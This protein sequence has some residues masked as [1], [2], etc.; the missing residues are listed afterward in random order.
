MDHSC[1]PLERLLKIMATLRSERGC[2]WDREQTPQSLSPYLTEET[3]EVLEAIELGD[4]AAICEELGDLLLQ[5]VFQAQIFSE[6]GD[7]D[8]H[9][10]AAGIADKMLRRHPHVFADDEHGGSEIHQRRWEEIKRAEKDAAGQP[11]TLFGG[12]PK[13]LPP[14]QRAEKVL[15]KAM[16]AGLEL[17]D[18][19][20]L[21][22]TMQSDLD[23][24]GQS[25]E[26]GQPVKQEQ[27]VGDMLFRLVVLSRYCAIDAGQ[28]LKNAIVRF[29]AE[30]MATELRPKTP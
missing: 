21:L 11:P 26:S 14:L 18:A 20:I 29:E 28:A 4:V 22:H 25:I 3:F 17:P 24:L 8:F 2:P 5:I 19:K 27:I 7:F 30:S 12:I 1:S 9:D 13:A 15:T 23:A 6:R 16:R 10:V